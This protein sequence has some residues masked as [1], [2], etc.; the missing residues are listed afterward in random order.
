MRYVGPRII[1]TNPL[2]S[3]QHVL[4]GLRKEPLGYKKN[5]KNDPG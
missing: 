4:D 2:L 3:L 1:L 5:V